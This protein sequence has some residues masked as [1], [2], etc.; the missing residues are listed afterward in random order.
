[1][2][3]QYIYIY[4]YTKNSWAVSFCYR[5]ATQSDRYFQHGTMAFLVALPLSCKPAKG[6]MLSLGTLGGY[7]YI[8]IS[9]A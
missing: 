1:M 2:Y 6:P 3:I 8:Y 5:K 4:I 7:V 9:A